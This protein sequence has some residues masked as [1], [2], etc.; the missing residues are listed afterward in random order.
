MSFDVYL[1]PSA[2]SPEGEA[3]QTA[4]DRALAICGARRGGPGEA[5]VVLASGAELEFFHGDDDEDAGGMFALRSIAVEA[6]NLIFELADATGCFIIF[7]SDR[8]RLLRTPS[9]DAELPE[10]GPDDLADIADAGELERLLLTPF[11]DHADYVSQVTG[12]PPEPAS[13]PPPATDPSLLDRFFKRP[14]KD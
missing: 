6:V 13:E 4:F 10:G 11:D 8:P 1:I 5:D 3:A 7:P 14:N 9:N 2:A 12:A